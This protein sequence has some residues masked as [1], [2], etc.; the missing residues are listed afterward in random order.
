MKILILCVSV[1]V[2]LG[3]AKEA[4]P[5]PVAAKAV[6]TDTQRKKGDNSALIP[7]ANYVPPTK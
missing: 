6:D 4:T 3:C 1:L 2:V 5:P 7:P